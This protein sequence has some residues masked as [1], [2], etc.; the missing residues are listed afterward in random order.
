[1][2]PFKSS[3]PP[4]ART[5]HLNHHSDGSCVFL[6]DQ[7]RCR[8]HERFGY[9][10]KPLP[11]RL[12]PFILIPAGDHWRVGMRYACPSAAGNKGRGIADHEQALREFAAELA[13]REGLDEKPNALKLVPP[14]LQGRQR[15]DWPDILCLMR[16]LLALLQNHNDRMERRWRK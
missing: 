12:F 7:G 4:W 15:V 6:S 9:Q 14:A 1:I 8:V 11:C 13:R 3:G 5:Y 10:V 16:A 2:A